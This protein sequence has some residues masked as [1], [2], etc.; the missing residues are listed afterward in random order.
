MD[1]FEEV[2]TVIGAAVISAAVLAIPILTACSFTLSWDVLSKAVLCI[3]TFLDYLT[4]I[5]V[6]VLMADSDI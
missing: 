1:N 2:L 6:T 5:C 3:F 4:I